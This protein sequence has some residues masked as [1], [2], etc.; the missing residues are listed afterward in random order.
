MPLT[1]EIWAAEGSG[2]SQ[3]LAELVTKALLGYCYLLASAAANICLRDDLFWT[4]FGLGL[5]IV[6]MT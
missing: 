2:L 3:T 5:C 4:L 1:Q 6:I